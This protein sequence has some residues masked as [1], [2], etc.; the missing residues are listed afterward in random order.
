MQGWDR[1][2]FP[3]QGPTSNVQRLDGAHG[4]TP[5]SAWTFDVGHSTLDIE[6][7]SA[8]HALDIQNAGD[9]FNRVNHFIQVLDVKHL[10]RHLNMSLLVGSYRG[11][12]VANAT[13][14]ATKSAASTI[15]A[16]EYFVMQAPRRS[17]AH[18]SSR[19]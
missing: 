9:T 16:T 4:T 17:R 6:L 18:G 3:V 5:G 1:R 13:P 11:T 15:T 10:H 19:A 8:L 7:Y 12:R 2:K 14:I